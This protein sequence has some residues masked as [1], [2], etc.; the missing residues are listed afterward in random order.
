V[1]RKIL[2]VDD[3]KKTVDLVRLYLEKDGYQVLL[4]YDGQAA[5][6]L[7]RQKRP[8]LIVLDVMLPKLDGLDLCRVLRRRPPSSADGAPPKTTSCWAGPGL[9]DFDQA[10]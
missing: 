5:L 4:A 1:K 2:V 9:D 10:L 6:E 8:D 3:D 7:A